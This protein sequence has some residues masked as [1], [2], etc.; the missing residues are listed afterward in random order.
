MRKCE[1]RVLIIYNSFVTFCLG[2]KYSIYEF[3]IS[4]KKSGSEVLTEDFRQGE[5]QLF[6]KRYISASTI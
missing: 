1:E 2:E 6:F 5:G 3:T 4:I